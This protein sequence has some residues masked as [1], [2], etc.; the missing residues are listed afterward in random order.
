MDF[1]SYRKERKA[2][3][4]DAEAPTQDELKNVAKKY[5]GKSDSEMLGEIAKAA[6]QE[7]Q[8]GNYSD[9]KLDKFASDL[10]PMLNAEQRERLAK[11]IRM[12]KGG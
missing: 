7:R 9:E 3:R 4:D 2:N 6:E 10:A 1:K 5:E 12:I 8:N 11:A